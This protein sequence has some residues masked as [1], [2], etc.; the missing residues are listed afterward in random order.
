M[1]K[2]LQDRSVYIYQFELSFSC[3][4]EHVT[5]TTHGIRIRLD[6]SKRITAK[7]SI[8]ILC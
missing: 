7:A 2:R 8:T 6:D 5:N 4:E 3:I 1:Q